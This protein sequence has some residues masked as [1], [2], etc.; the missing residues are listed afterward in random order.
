MWITL[1]RKCWIWWKLEEERRKLTNLL[2]A[3]EELKQELEDFKQ[4]A[5]K[6]EDEL[7]THQTRLL[8]EKEEYRVKVLE[9]NKKIE[10]MKIAVKNDDTK[11]FIEK[12]IS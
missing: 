8:L 4:N 10:Q 5:L 2:K 9:L 7:K 12:K 1:S 3:E 11:S 6:S